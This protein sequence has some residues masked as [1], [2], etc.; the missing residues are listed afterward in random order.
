MNDKCCYLFSVTCQY[1][2]ISSLSVF[3]SNALIQ[4]II[5]NCMSH[6]TDNV[7]DTNNDKNI[8]IELSSEKVVQLH[9]TR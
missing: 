4:N 6:Q 3:Y 7:I 5:L 2:H 1:F 9:I 8:I